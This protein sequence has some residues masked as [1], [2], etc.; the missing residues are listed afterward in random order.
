M[1]DSLV[2]SSVWRT[3]FKKPL[4]KYPEIEIIHLDYV[5]PSCDA[6]HLGGR[7]ST[8]IARVKGAPYDP[9]TFQVCCCPPE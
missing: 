4:E 3:E 1:R 9:L 5:D 8:R 7:L 2:T 6:C